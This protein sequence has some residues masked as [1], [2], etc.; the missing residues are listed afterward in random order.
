MRRRGKFLV[1]MLS[2]GD[3]VVLHLRMTGSLLL[4]PLDYTLEKHTHLVISLDC[5]YR[6][7]FT[8]PR[9]FGRFGWYRVAR[10]IWSAAFI[11]WAWSLLTVF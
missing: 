6:L 2:S 1:I 11:G 9:R 5:G 10:R 3:D 8:D 4:V 7:C